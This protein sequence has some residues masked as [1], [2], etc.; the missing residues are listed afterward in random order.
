MGRSAIYLL[1]T[2]LGLFLWLYPGNIASA[3]SHDLAADWSDA[4]N[5]NGVWSYRSGST[6]LPGV[7]DWTLLT[8]PTVQPAWAPGQTIPAWFKSVADNPE[9]M[10]FLTGDVVVHSAGAAELSA[11]VTWTSPV[12]SFI[13]IRGAAWMVRE[14]GRS[15][16]WILLRNGVVISDG[17]LFSGDPYSRASPFDFA[18]GAAGAAA[19][20]R[21]PVLVD[22]SIELRIEQTS[23]SGDFVAV[24]L[25]IIDDPLFTD[26]FE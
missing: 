17:S 18:E 14:L 22:D 2:L 23:G 6:V 20:Q 11:N 5:P 19:L 9:G 8:E 26:G 4:A 12:D 13:V 3:T 24:R 10:D 25:E 21:I 15:N 1:E 16:N 7:G